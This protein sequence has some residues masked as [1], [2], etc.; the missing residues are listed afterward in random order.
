MTQN[1]L[2]QASLLTISRLSIVGKHAIPPTERWH[3]LEWVSKNLPQNIKDAIA[4][5]DR[6]QVMLL[7][8][9]AVM[10]VPVLFNWMKDEENLSFLNDA[11]SDLQA[12]LLSKVTEEHKKSAVDA[13]VTFVAQRAAAKAPVTAPPAGAP[14]AQAPEAPIPGPG[15][16]TPPPPPDP[17]VRKPGRPRR[18][19]PM[20]PTEGTVPPAGAPE[21]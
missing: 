3:V 11:M 6:E 1:E 14:A 17:A 8:S 18:A 12:L 21:G 13:N 7:S 16:Q 2:I 15:A 9:T 5:G 19:P 10:A 4:A 20:P